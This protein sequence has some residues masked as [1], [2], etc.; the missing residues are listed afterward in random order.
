MICASLLLLTF[1]LIL[2]IYLLFQTL[3]RFS[4]ATIHDLILAVH[5]MDVGELGDLFD[6]VKDENLRIPDTWTHRARMLLEYLRRMGFNVFMIL[7]WAYAEQERH[8]G[9]GV[10]PDPD[11]EQALE[12]IVKNGIQLR[13]YVL[14]SRA[15]L[16]W[17][18]VRN[19]IGLRPTRGLASLRWVGQADGLA[20]YRRLAESVCSFSRQYGSDTYRRLVAALWGNEHS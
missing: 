5:R 14:S 10:S 15:T 4:P 8:A 11:K 18:L 9:A 12:E 13:L 16:A 6:A 20:V 2:S 7:R 3:F 1:L 17:W 19:A